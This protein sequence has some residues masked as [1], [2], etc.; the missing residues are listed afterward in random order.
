MALIDATSFKAAIATAAADITTAWTD[1]VETETAHEI[2]NPN[3][4]LR[5]LK[6]LFIYNPATGVITANDAYIDAAYA[7]A[8]PAVGAG[9]DKVSDAA[10]PA[11][12]SAVVENAAPA[13]IVLTFDRDVIIANNV[14]LNLSKVVDSIA[15]VGPVVTI[16]VTAAYVNGNVITVGGEFVSDAGGKVTLSAEAVTNN[17]A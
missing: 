7:G 12:V 6:K 3:H 17:V 15:F 4:P 8:F 9:F 2:S 10:L 13:D 5:Q 11:L 16:T 14:V 1:D